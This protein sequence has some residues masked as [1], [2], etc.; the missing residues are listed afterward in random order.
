[1]PYNP[2]LQHGL[3]TPYFEIYLNG[4]EVE[5]KLYDLVQEITYEDHESGSDLVYI[6]LTDPSLYFIDNPLIVKGAKIKIRGG[7]VNDVV[8]WLDGYISLIDVEFPED[9]VPLIIITCMDESFAL[10]KFDKKATYTEM[11]FDQLVSTVIQNGGY[12]LEIDSNAPKLEK[13]YEELSQA[14]ESDLKFLLRIAEENKI[15]LK[16]KNGKIT[17]WHL[18]EEPVVQTDLHW[19]EYP[20]NLKRASFRYVLADEETNVEV[21]N[22]DIDTKEDQKG[23]ASPETPI[24]EYY[25]DDTDTW[26]LR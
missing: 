1:M 14:N 6:H 25:K 16:I 26:R 13:V 8:D 3:L 12:K 9:G 15:G 11:T 5:D 23:V 18:F 19:R 7:W 2:P 21:E 24:A 20:Y 10:D 22:V 17:W 4:K